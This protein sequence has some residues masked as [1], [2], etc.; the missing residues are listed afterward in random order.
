MPSPENQLP[1]LDGKAD[2]SASRSRSKAAPAYCFKLVAGQAVVQLN[3]DPTRCLIR[4]E[5]EVSLK[6]NL[7][8]DRL[9]KHF[10]S[11]HIN[12]YHFVSSPHEPGSSQRPDQAGDRL[13]VS[14]N[15]KMVATSQQIFGL[16]KA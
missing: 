7:S 5:H 3:A 4:R 6:C 16:E 1:G 13:K 2:R 8:G 11:R 15:C 12:A 14:L 9:Y 10:R